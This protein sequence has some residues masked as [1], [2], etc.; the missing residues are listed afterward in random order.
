MGFFDFSYGPGVDS[1]NNRATAA[2]PESKLW[3]HD[4]FWWATLY[5]PTA[6]GHRIHQ[7]S[8]S[9]QTWIDTGVLVDE[10]R[11]SRQDVL[12]DGDRLYVVSRFAGAPAQNRFIRFGYDDGTHVYVPDTGYPVNIPGGGTESMSV[13]KDS[14]GRLWIAYT[15]ASQVYVGCTS[16][17]DAEWSAPFVVPGSAGDA[18]AA[19][20]IATVQALRDGTLG[21]FWSNQVTETD[22]F[23]VHLDEAGPADPEAWHV[24]IAAQGNRVADDHFN[25]KVTSD[26]RL[27]AAIKTSRTAPSATLIG[28]LER[29]PQGHWSPLR[30]VATVQYTPTRPALLLDEDARRVYVFYSDNTSGIYFKTS[31]LDA[32]AFPAGRGTPFI[33]S[34]EAPDLNNPTTTKQNVSA[35]TGLV[36]EASSPGQSVY[37]HNALGVI[38]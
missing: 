29:S 28:V 18:L 2:K 32:I 30:T 13:A 3:Y 37:W 16:G 19:D 4:G 7:L 25:L 12:A 36:V 21:V 27:L 20:D 22:Y 5:S 23:A 6:H 26:N 1:N 14:T 9:R 38:P 31:S 34:A 11:G 17:T 35:M 24:E 15:L 8:A 33:Q 10:R